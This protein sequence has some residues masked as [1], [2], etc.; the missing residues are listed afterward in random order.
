MLKE[1]T[2]DLNA[3]PKAKVHKRVTD[4]TLK[5]ESLANSEPGLWFAGDFDNACECEFP[6]VSE[7]MNPYLGKTQRYRWCCLLTELQK[8]F[9]H[10][11]EMVDA[12]L[13]RNTGKIETEPHKWDH[14]MVMP[15][16]LAKRIAR[17]AGKT[18]EQV[19]S[20]NPPV[21]K[22]IVEQ[23]MAEPQRYPLWRRIL[24]IGR[25]H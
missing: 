1:L 8:I 11:F 15:D 25:L 23:Q 24:N 3:E 5:W 7:S 19:L 2:T 9:P 4:T 17:A 16:H 22:P 10:L 12:Y 13:D 21:P 20:E 18:M 14:D 6:S